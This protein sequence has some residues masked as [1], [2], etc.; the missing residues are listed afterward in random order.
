MPEL[1]EVE[2][3]RAGL[4]ALGR[5]PHRRRPSRCGTRAR[6][7][8]PRRRRRP[9]RPPA[10]RPHRRVA[11][12]GKYLWLPLADDGVP[13]GE[14]LIAH[15]G[16]SGQLLVQPPDARRREAPARAD[17]L[18]RRRARTAVRRPAHVRR[19]AARPAGADRRPPRPELCRRRSRTSRATRSTPPSTTRS[20]RAPAPARIRGQAGAARPDPGV[21]DRQHL[22]RRVAVAGEAA[23][24]AARRR[25]CPAPTVLGLLAHVRAVLAE[26]LRPAGRPSTRSTS[27]STARAA[28]STGRS[29]ST[30]GRAGRARGAAPRSGG[31]R[32]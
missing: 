4:A 1:P 26:A 19:G 3:V 15:L 20:S 32:S 31:R 7:P 28:T 9:R 24:R 22:R 8:P 12:R 21:G 13:R 5:R 27:T 18:H 29:R 17:H 6:A 23:R 14:A 10:R 16:M 30:G 25:P 11:R 2:T